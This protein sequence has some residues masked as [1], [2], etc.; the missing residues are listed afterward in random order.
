MLFVFSG[1]GNGKQGASSA[2][3]FALALDPRDSPHL[4]SFLG[5]RERAQASRALGRAHMP[6]AGFHGGT[7]AED[8]K[9]RLKK[10]RK[11]EESQEMTRD[12]EEAI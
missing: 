9:E 2:W 4:L 7:V 3:G 12:Q 10:Q 1:F 5:D 11:E 6:S 8:E